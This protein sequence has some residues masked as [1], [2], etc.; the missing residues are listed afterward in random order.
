MHLANEFF[1][2]AACDEHV[3]IALHRLF[4]RYDI[5]FKMALPARYESVNVFS[6]PVR[7]EIP[8]V[9]ECVFRAVK[10]FHGLKKIVKANLCQAAEVFLRR[11][12]AHLYARPL[13]LPADMELW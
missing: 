10:D 1:V 7:D 6:S 12:G 4:T 11:V 9:R 2:S 13:L 8:D 5:G 3:A